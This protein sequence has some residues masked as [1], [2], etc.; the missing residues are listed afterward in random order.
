[1]TS[2]PENDFPLCVH[3][4]SGFGTPTTSHSSLIFWPTRAIIF[5]SGVMKDGIAVCSETRGEK[6]VI[7]IQMVSVG[8]EHAEYSPSILRLAEH[9]REPKLLLALQVYTD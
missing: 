2:R 7:S 4:N 6:E 5:V 1:M 8:C 9:W 3:V